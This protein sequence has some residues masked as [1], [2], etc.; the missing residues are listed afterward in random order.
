MATFADYHVHTN[1]SYDCKIPMADMCKEAIAR[2]VSEIAFTD[3]FNN[4]LFDVDLGCYDPEQ[5]F[6][7]IATCRKKYPQLTIRAAV[8]V[9]EP[10]RWDA[11]VR[12]MLERY[13]YDV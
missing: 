7:D 9:G 2:G 10:H 13:P 12:P 5:Y 3:H 11:K 8:E 6:A 4:H 1:N